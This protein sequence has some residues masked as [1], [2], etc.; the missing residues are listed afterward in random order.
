[1]SIG[2]ILGQYVIW[3][4]NRKLLQFVIDT[5]GA[6]RG[7]IIISGA[8]FNSDR[9]CFILLRPV[10]GIIIIVEVLV[11]ANNVVSII[12]ETNFQ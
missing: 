1:L 6:P 2:I 4:K 3:S 11:T 8:D 10:W 12:R 7:I 5:L 9:P